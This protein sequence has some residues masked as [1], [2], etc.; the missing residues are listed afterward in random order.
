MNYEVLQD[1]QFP[2]DWRVEAID[3]GSGEIY[4][5]IFAGPNAKERAQ[6][7]AD[8]QNSNTCKHVEWREPID[9]QAEREIICAKC[10]MVGERNSNGGTYYP[11]T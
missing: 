11:A 3:T 8:W 2:T 7:F 1:R 6:Q 4:V 5:A 10:G 9:S